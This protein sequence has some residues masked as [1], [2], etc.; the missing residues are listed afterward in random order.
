MGLEFLTSATFWSAAAAVATF[1]A[2]AIALW[3]GTLPA[4]MDRDRQKVI[5]TRLLSAVFEELRDLQRVLGVDGDEMAEMM[6]PAMAANGSQQHE[7]FRLRYFIG[8]LNA[9]KVAVQYPHIFEPELAAALLSVNAKMDRLV[10]LRQAILARH[11]DQADAREEVRITWNALSAAIAHLSGLVKPESLPP[12]EPAV[13]M[14]GSCLIYR[15]RF[16]RRSPRS[17]LAIRNGRLCQRMTA[18]IR[19]PDHGARWATSAIFKMLIIR[20]KYDV[21]A[22]SCPHPRPHPCP[23]SCEPT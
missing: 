6:V 8:P 16:D 2:A 20:A 19:E 22:R 5:R 15:I 9:L 4:R 18:A 17:P 13:Q 3:V 7:G 23:R 1:A 14:G 12:A 10:R 21:V 11:S